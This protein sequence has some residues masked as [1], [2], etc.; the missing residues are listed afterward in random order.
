MTRTEEGAQRLE[1]LGEKK[2]GS[3]DFGLRTGIEG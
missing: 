1:C 2:S 3:E